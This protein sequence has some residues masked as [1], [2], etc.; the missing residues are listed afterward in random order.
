[1]SKYL[2]QHGVDMQQDAVIQAAI[3]QW[4]KATRAI[5]DPNTMLKQI[6]M[7]YGRQLDAAEKQLVVEQ[8][9]K[10]T[11]KKWDI[12]SGIKKRG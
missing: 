5:I 6:I 1:M 11:N 8:V 2:W 4:K 7:Q 9:L 3:V 10:Q 12:Y